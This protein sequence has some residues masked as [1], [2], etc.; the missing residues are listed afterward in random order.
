[1]KLRTALLA[2]ALALA[3]VVSV[4]AP[5]QATLDSR[6]QIRITG[7]AEI[8]PSGPVTPGVPDYSRTQLRI[9]VTV[10]CPAG[11]TAYVSDAGLPTFFP[12][13]DYRAF[14]YLPAH[15]APTRVQCTG[16]WVPSYA[17]ALSIYR[18]QDPSTGPFRRFTP[19][20]R[21]VA[22]V[23]IYGKPSVTD[24]KTVKVQLPR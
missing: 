3:P 21:L 24:I 5:A 16:K 14:P 19:G 4:A 7:T 6:Y 12:P 10:R 11:E 13:P 22:Q 23:A 9:P 17:Y 20:S 1:M 15:T 8:L 18:M 2:S